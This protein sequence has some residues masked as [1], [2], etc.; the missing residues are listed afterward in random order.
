MKNQQPEMVAGFYSIACTLTAIA[1]F[2]MI[3]AKVSKRSQSNKNTE[4]VCARRAAEVYF[5]LAK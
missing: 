2:A 3:I 5:K 1:L 4:T